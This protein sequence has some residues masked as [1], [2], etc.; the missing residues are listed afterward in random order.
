MDEAVSS[1]KDVKAKLDALAG[2]VKVDLPGG[3]AAPSA[4]PAA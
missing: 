2:T 3:S 1:A 4:A